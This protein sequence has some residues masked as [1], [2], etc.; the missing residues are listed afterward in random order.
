MNNPNPWIFGIHAVESAL[1]NHPEDVIQIVVVKN[2][3]NKRLLRVIEWIRS[4]K[5]HIIYE[6]IEFLDAQVSD[7][8]Q[9]IIAHIAKTNYNSEKQLKQDVTTWDQPLILVLDN[10]E[11][12]RNLG[13]CLRSADA[14]GVT[15][16]IMTKNKSAP[17]TAITRKTAAGAVDHLAIYQVSNLARALEIIKEAGVWVYGTDCSEESNSIYQTDLKGSVAI[18]VGNEGK[19]L[20]HLVK[21]QCD[22]LIHIPMDGSVQS[23]NVSVATGISLFEAKRQRLPDLN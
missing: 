11:D 21:Q 4:Q 5:L 18:V 3:S 16:V 19:G 9:G 14:V 6:N 17:I 10:L 22:H 23:L 7:R 15:A 20:R 12:P 13:A 2:P 1:K 8:H